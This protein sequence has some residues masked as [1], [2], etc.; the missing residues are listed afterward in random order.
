MESEKN[1]IYDVVDI[2]SIV[3]KKLDQIPDNI[4][5]RKTGYYIR[6]VTEIKEIILEL[7]AIELKLIFKENDYLFKKITIKD[8][9]G[10]YSTTTSLSIFISKY[11][12]KETKEW[13]DQVR[14]T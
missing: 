3:S 8:L 11:F 6:W 2:I 4:T 9:G 14:L 5:E 7:I 13:K 10:N 1:I 12:D